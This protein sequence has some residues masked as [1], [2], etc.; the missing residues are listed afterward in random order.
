VEDADR[1]L[2]MDD[3]RVAAFDTPE[4]LLETCP[5]YQEVYNSQS[6]SGSGD[7]DEDSRRDSHQKGGAR[8]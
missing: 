5:I 7:F 8:A 3:G 2:V 4:R 6:Q 1:V